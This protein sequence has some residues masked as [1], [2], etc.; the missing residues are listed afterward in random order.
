V[1]L[2]SYKALLFSFLKYY[3][4]I[5]GNQGSCVAQLQ[6]FMPL[7][8]P[9]MLSRC[10]LHGAIA[11]VLTCSVLLASASL[12]SVPL[13]FQEFPEHPGGFA[14]GTVTWANQANPSPAAQDFDVL[15]TTGV[16]PSSGK[17]I[18]AA[19]QDGTPDLTITTAVTDFSSGRWGGLRGGKS[20]GGLEAG[21]L[22]EWGTSRPGDAAV[23][24]IELRF[25]PAL[26]L[27]AGDFAMRLISANGTSELYEWTMITLG[28]ASDAPFDVASLDEYSALDYNN[29]RSGSFYSTAG[30]PSGLAGTAQRLGPGRSI[31]QFLRGAPGS[32]VSG[33]LVQPG[34]YSI[35][36]FNAGVFD[37]PEQYLDNPLPGDGSID[38]NQTITGAS[39]GL[40]PETPLSAI[41]IWFGYHD[42]GFD[43][44]GDGFT[45]TD[46]N[47]YERVAGLTLGSFE[48]TIPVPE[49]GAISL[50]L[51]LLIWKKTRR[52]IN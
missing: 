5:S 48:T 4:Q 16:E 42:V 28:K 29:T 17:P 35:D 31:S 10:S 13:S 51:G 24:S 2:N 52:I 32:A 11:L 38:D 47:I 20:P 3:L 25:D 6:K 44:D 33:G 12:W 27:T 18:Y 37:G 46:N 39:L 14:P 21:A 22:V 7:P 45:A 34:W 40:D 41:T 15:R 43:S 9:S 30:L 8:L 49:P 1:L 36:D 26:H 19:G 50:L 23:V